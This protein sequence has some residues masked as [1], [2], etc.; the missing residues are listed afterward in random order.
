MIEAAD[1]R[2]TRPGRRSLM[3]D[4]TFAARLDHLFRTVHPQGRGEYSY[5]EVAKAI[6]DRHG[7]TI[8]ASYLNQ[9]RTGVK[10]N[11]T[12]RHIEALATFFGVP[13][14]YFF[15]DGAAARIDAE[16]DLLAALRD[17]GVRQIAMRAAGLPPQGLESVRQII[18]LARSVSGLQDGDDAG[19]ATR[20]GS[21]GP[22]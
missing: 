10:D 13:A 16:L 3:D 18:E 6:D 11:P 19:T 22:E 15:D 7:P 5:R 21:P 8:S 1:P 12:K 17:S 4:G 9:L 2:E 20:D 14:A